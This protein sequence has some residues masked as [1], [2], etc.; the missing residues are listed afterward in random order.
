MHNRVRTQAHIFIAGGTFDTNGGCSSGYIQKLAEALEAA[1]PHVRF[2]VLNGG[3]Y[4]ELRDCMAALK[5]V[6]AVLWFA[7]VP[8]DLPKLL[9]TLKE[10]LPGTMLV[11]SKNNRRGAYTRDQLCERMADSGA[12]LLLEFTKSTD[13]LFACTVLRHNGSVVLESATSISMVASS[14]AAALPSHTMTV[15]GPKS[16]CVIGE[17]GTVSQALRVRLD[18]TPGVRVK[19]LATEA[20]R[21][22][23]REGEAHDIYEADLVV[24]ATDGFSSPDIFERIPRSIR[25]LDVS[26]SFRQDRFWEYGLPEIGGNREHTAVAPRVANPGCFATSA[27]LLLSPLLRAGLLSPSDALYLDGVGGYTTGGA[28]LVEQADRGDLPPEAVYSLSS[29]HRHIAEI[30]A[31]AGIEPSTPVW[32]TPKIGNFPRGIRMQIPLRGVGRRE[33][34]VTFNETYNGTAVKVE[35][36]T[37][38]RLAGDAW[39]NRPGACLY[40]QEMQGGTLAICVLDN[41]GK[42]AVDSALENIQ[43]MLGL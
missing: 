12:T 41:L 23:L 26:P 8:N 2:T 31:H 17:R 40:A 27:I 25:V 15:S 24:L 1:L 18:E 43:L 35:H 20:A 22:L 13:G 30:R 6:S 9:P 37:P 7:D 21:Q 29:E 4:E 34:L 32:F 39:A 33:V 28:R 19:A 5:Q 36:V 38:P 11:Q 3:T 16:I 10:R 42:G 14:L